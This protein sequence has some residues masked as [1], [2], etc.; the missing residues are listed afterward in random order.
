MIYNAQLE[1]LTYICIYLMGAR[2][3]YYTRGKDRP[4]T[5]KPVAIP[6]WCERS[7]SVGRVLSVARLSIRLRPGIPGY[8]HLPCLD[9]IPFREI[10][11][12]E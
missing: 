3:E 10:N 12:G 5:I 2:L 9:D 4:R 7:N 11:D 1:L 6:R 8:D